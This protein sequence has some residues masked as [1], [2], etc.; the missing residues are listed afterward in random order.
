MANKSYDSFVARIATRSAAITGARVLFEARVLLGKDHP[1]DQK[2]HS[3][4]LALY[5]RA[6]AIEKKKEGSSDG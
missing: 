4:E 5:Q 3:F 1:D 2:L 6:E